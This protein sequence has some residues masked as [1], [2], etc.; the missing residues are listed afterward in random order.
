[1]NETNEQTWLVQSEGGSHVYDNA[2]DAGAAFFQADIAALPQVI[3]RE[4]ST[5]EHRI[6]FTAG[7]GT[8]DA[9]FEK[10]LDL[11]LNIEMLDTPFRDGY[12]DALERAVVMQLEEA[13]WDVPASS[14]DAAAVLGEKLSDD[15]KALQAIDPRRS[16]R[17]WMT[18]APDNVDA[19]EF[20]ELPEDTAQS[21]APAQGAPAAAPLS[22]RQAAAAQRRD[23]LAGVVEVARKFIETPVEL[24][25]SQWTSVEK[26][27][28]DLLAVPIDSLTKEQ[29][30]ELVTDDLKSFRNTR[31][32]S[33]AARSA[34]AMAWKARNQSAYLAVIEEM[35]PDVAGMLKELS[36]AEGEH[37][38]EQGNAIEPGPELDKDVRSWVANRWGAEAARVPE[39]A[40]GDDIFD[41]ARSSV[42]DQTT[43]DDAGANTEYRR[44]NVDQ[45]KLLAPIPQH[46]KRRF[47]AGEKNHYYFD[48]A[49]Q[50]LAFVDKGLRLETMDNSPVVAESFV[51]IAMARGWETIKVKGSNDFRREVWMAASIAGAK[52]V[53]YDPTE[54]DKEALEQKMEQRGLSR[55][56]A[57]Q[58]AGVDV[59]TIEPGRDKE[60]EK[61]AAAASTSRIDR[62]Q[63]DAPQGETAKPKD[64]LSGKIVAHGEAPF[65]FDDKNDPSYFVRLEQDGATR[66][67]WGKGLKT[68]VG[69]ADA[70]VGDS[71]SLKRVHAEP[72][73]VTEKIRD[74]DGKVIGEQKKAAKFNSWLVEKAADFRNLDPQHSLAKH[75]DLIDAHATM[76]TTA[77]ALANKYPNMASHIKEKFRDE[78]ANRVERGESIKAP[79]VAAA[80]AV[81]RSPEAARA[82]TRQTAEQER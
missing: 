48:P 30:T 25:V 35:S 6:A 63:S 40:S 24:P 58:R 67:V 1:M 50:K 59:N 61:G 57:S 23:L 36:A 54:G 27:Y 43:R 5:G 19:P 62:D 52:V 12:T 29:A 70:D 31:D 4:E 64:P 75:P 73:T 2:Y 42:A 16:S 7:D 10:K 68:A 13:K 49:K 28:K 14:N 44:V 74:G 76:A 41:E 51:E 77:T 39:T 33:R 53:G 32:R 3:H 22:K 21:P 45:G 79:K 20:L 60:Q 17:V 37:A 46:V 65:N 72:V 81:Q 80:K 15:L 9:P 78:L 69:Q 11:A 8:A 66:E 56:E 34:L 26:G 82:M 38:A 55:K 18:H 71:V 47:I